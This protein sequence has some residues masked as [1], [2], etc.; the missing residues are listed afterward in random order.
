MRLVGGGGRSLD[1]GL[2]TGDDVSAAV[3][4]RRSASMSSVSSCGLR[5]VDGGVESIRR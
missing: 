2:K 3:A 5:S 1:G 4:A